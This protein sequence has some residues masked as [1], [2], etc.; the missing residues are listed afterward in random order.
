MKARDK[1]QNLFYIILFLYVQLDPHQILIL[2][3]IDRLFTVFTLL[4]F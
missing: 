1:K 2:R 4:P 3:K